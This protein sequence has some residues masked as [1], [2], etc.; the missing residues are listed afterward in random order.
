[1]ALASLSS[2]TSTIAWPIRRSSTWPTA[3][4]LACSSSARWPP[5]TTSRWRSARPCTGGRRPSSC[6]RSGSIV[7]EE[8]AGSNGDG[9]MPADDR[10]ALLQ[11][12]VIAEPSAGGPLPSATGTPDRSAFGVTGRHRLPPAALGRAAVNGVT[13]DAEQAWPPANGTS[14]RAPW[15]SAP[16]PQPPVA[17]LWDAE[18]TRPWPDAFHRKGAGAGAVWHRPSQPARRA[19]GQTGAARRARPAPP[20][21]GQP[22]PAPS[23]PATRRRAIISACPSGSRRPAWRRNCG[24]GDRRRQGRRRRHGTRPTSTSGRRR[25]LAP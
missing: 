18:A 14:P 6:S 12:T 9:E 13:G 3:S 7:R 24:G 19:P 8:E 5:G 11:G 25:R 17:P 1:M 4:S 16:E 2:L 15:E 22:G 21:A 20:A 10:Q 23:R